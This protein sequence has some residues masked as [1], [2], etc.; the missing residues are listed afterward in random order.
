MKCKLFFH[1]LVFLDY[2]FLL[3][4]PTTL[5]IQ[6]VNVTCECSKLGLCRSSV[7]LVHRAIS[8]HSRFNVVLRHFV[9][10]SY[11]SLSH[12]KFV[13]RSSSWLNL[14]SSTGRAFYYHDSWFLTLNHTV[15]D[16]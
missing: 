12:K 2:L 5:S 4:S 3:Y 8:M 16:T 10:I 15:S 9:Q 11:S 14:G 13:G 1:E 6:I 7:V